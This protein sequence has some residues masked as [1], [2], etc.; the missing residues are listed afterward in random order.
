[1]KNNK[2]SWE[3]YETISF[4]PCNFTEKTLRYLYVNKLNLENVDWQ[5]LPGGILDL[6]ERE[7]KICLTE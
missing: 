1:M 2:I 3:V 7:N 4:V 5:L 6:K